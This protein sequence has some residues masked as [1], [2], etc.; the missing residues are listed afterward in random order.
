LRNSSVAACGCDDGPS[1]W[2]V[3]GLFTRRAR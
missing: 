3:L 2:A 1:S